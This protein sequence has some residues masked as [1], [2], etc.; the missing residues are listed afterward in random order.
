[1]DRCRAVINCQIDMK[2]QVLVAAVPTSGAQHRMSNELS[3][4]LPLDT[5]EIVLPPHDI[6]SPNDILYKEYLEV[7]DANDDHMSTG[8]VSNED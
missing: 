7:R 6:R 4:I 8:M 1:M 2:Y 3:V 5:S